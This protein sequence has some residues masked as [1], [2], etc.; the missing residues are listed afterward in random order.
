MSGSTGRYEEGD[1]DL[2]VLAAH[3]G[4][5]TPLA[6]AV[7]T[8]LACGPAATPDPAPAKPATVCPPPGPYGYE[9]GA[10]IADLRFDDCDGNPVSL[11]DLCGADAGLVVNFYGWC[12]SCYDFVRLAGELDKS[13][14]GLATFVVITEDPAQA[15]ASA[16]YCDSIRTRYGLSG[17]VAI[18]PAKALEAYGTTDLVMVTGRSG[19]IAFLRNNAT[20]AAVTAAVDE[21][22]GR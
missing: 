11:H 9:R 15:P 14:S 7:L 1:I 5:A 3:G 4:R 12:P 8:L 16:D 18:D 19:K 21:Q 6:G 20:E 17:T 10:T 22:L 2:F 13:R